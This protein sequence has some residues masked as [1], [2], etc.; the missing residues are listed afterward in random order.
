MSLPTIS[1][2]QAL[3]IAPQTPGL[4]QLPQLPAKGETVK[5]VGTTHWAPPVLG[6]ALPTPAIKLNN[7]EMLGRDRVYLPKH[8]MEKV[9][10][11]GLR[12]F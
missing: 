10:R 5:K 9:H 12:L 11:L 6:K 2:C 7:P 1:G 8:I 4:L 3:R